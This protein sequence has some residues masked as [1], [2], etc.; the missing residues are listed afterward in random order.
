MSASEWWWRLV[1]VQHIENIWGPDKPMGQRGRRAASRR[2][3]VSRRGGEEQLALLHR[4]EVDRDFLTWLCV[5]PASTKLQAVF[6]VRS[7]VK[8]VPMGL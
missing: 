5:V 3:A 1:G 4:V 2:F 8:V 7:E 6:Q